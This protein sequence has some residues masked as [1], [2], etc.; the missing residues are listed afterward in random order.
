MITD[1]ETRLKGTLRAC[2]AHEFFTNTAYFPI[3]KILLEFLTE[4]PMK[5]AT[6]P[7]FYGLVAAAIVQAYFLGSWQY[8][9]KPR[10]LLGNLIGPSLY[11]VF[12]LGIERSDDLFSFFANP[13]HFTYWSFSFAIGL[14]QEMGLRFSGSPG[15]A[16]VLFENLIRTNILLAGYWIFE[17]RTNPLYASLE[18]FLSDDSHVFISMA[19]MMIGLIVGFG[20][21]N[22][23]SSL[24]ILRRTAFQLRVYSE[25]LLGRNLLSQAVSDPA[26][27]TLQRRDRTVLFMDIRGFT[28]WS[29]YQPPEKVVAMLNSYFE[30]AEQVWLRFAT[31]KAKLSGDEIMV[32]F[33]TEED[34]SRAALELRKEIAPFLRA[35]GLDIGIGLYTGPLVEGLMG[36]KDVKGYDVVGDT[37]NTANR[38]CDAASDGE[39]LIS[40]SIYKAVSRLAV[41]LEPRHIM[42]KGKDEPLTVYSLQ[43][44]RDAATLAQHNR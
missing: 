33:S 12:E 35:Y 22:A 44:I 28:R 1:I 2:I 7:D 5:F 3:T 21:I 14:L 19:I 26:A 39:I 36:S 13:S 38:I 24:A 10:P 40:K 25:W 15:K 34:A 20:N 6:T 31:I 30:A 32:I 11:T 17:A 16:L 27:L 29:E 8:S 9:G 43:D 18:G 23:Q 37:V 4:G 41:V 42:V